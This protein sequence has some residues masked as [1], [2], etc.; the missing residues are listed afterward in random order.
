MSSDYLVVA[1]SRKSVFIPQTRVFKR[2]ELMEK[3][4]GGGGIGVYFQPWDFDFLASPVHV[5]GGAIL[6]YVAATEVAYDTSNKVRGTY[7]PFM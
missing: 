7:Y 4:K 6:E 2:N 3:V 1:G 5:P